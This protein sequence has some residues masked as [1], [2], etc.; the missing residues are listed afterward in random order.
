MMDIQYKILKTDYGK[1]WEWS[2]M[3]TPNIYKKCVI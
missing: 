2:E 3:I 1:S